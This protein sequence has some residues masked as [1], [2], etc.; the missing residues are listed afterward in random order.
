M[1]MNCVTTCEK[2]ISKGVTPATH[3]RSRRPSVRSMIKAED[4]KA[5]AKKKTMLKSIKSI[6]AFHVVKNLY[7]QTYVKITPGAT[8]SVNEGSLVP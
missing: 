5:T 6:K 2:R 4:V 1:T 3:E 8:K 7:S